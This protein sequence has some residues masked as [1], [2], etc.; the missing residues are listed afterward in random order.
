MFRNKDAQEGDDQ[1]DLTQL[2]E[3]WVKE[4][5]SDSV[6]PEPVSVDKQKQLDDE[7]EKQNKE[8]EREARNAQKELEKRKAEQKIQ[9]QMQLLKQEQNS[10]KLKN[11][12]G[13]MHLFF[14]KNEED[15]NASMS[16]LSI[17]H[18]ELHEHFKFYAT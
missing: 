16:L 11:Y 3:D 15:F 10:A 17:F 1:Y 7:E 8:K 6:E 18:L 9:A 2:T 14:H 12:F 5:F 4:F 13:V